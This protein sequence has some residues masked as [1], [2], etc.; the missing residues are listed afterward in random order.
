MTKVAIFQEVPKTK[1]IIALN[2]NRTIGEELLEQ[3]FK[4]L[5]EEISYLRRIVLELNCKVL[6]LEIVTQH[7]NGV[8]G[9]Y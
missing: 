3:E 8:S 9:G 2:G 7:L 4:F 5:R 1:E 6:N